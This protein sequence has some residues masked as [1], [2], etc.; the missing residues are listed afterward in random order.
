MADV[1]ADDTS[2][3]LR[4][5]GEALLEVKGS[6]FIAVVSPVETQQALQRALESVRAVHP[7]AT[8]HVPAWRLLDAAGQ[9]AEG[10]RDDGEPA[11]TAGRPMLRVLRGRQLVNVCAVVV[12]YYGGV[13]LGTG[14][15]ARAYAGALQAA[16]DI[17]EEIPWVPLSRAK[18]FAPFASL[19][20]LEQG[21][22]EAGLTVDTREFTSDGAWLTVSGDAAR[23]RS[24]AGRFPA[25]GGAAP[26]APTEDGGGTG[27]G[28]GGPAAGVS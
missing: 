20:A 18:L 11:G 10:A 17:T 23:V 25:P 3:T 2:M 9:P 21:A 8:H 15:L 13:K 12:R 27:P 24:L 5:P 7:R 28:S 26:T 14:G 19:S 4:T 22:A 1:M 6:R 16:L